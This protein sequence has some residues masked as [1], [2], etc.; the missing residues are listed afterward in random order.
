MLFEEAGIGSV[1]AMEGVVIRFYTTDPMTVAS[2]APPVASGAL[3]L[4]VGPN[5]TRG[6]ATVR[7]PLASPEA[8][9]VRVLD[10][11]GREVA[12]LAEGPQASGAHAWQ[13]PVGLASGVYAVEASAGERRATRLVTVVR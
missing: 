6:A 11:L 9:R 7:L 12:V 10:V 4:T 13:L 8:V 5:P 2:E 1:A 3:A